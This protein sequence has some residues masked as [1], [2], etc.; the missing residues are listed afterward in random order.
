MGGFFVRK[1]N[2]SKIFRVVI[3][4][5]LIAMQIV[6][7]RLLSINLTYL[8]IGFSFIPLMFAAYLYGPAGGVIVA[9]VSDLIGAIA[10]PSGPFFPG[11]TVTAALSG[12]IFGLTFHKNL[13]TPKIVAGVIANEVICSLLLNTLWLSILYTSA[14]SVLI[15]SR[16]WQCIVMAT[17]QIAFAEVF[18]HRLKIA[19]KLKVEVLRKE[20]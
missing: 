12:F 8:K 1:F 4:S 2:N 11:F 20:K 3:I 15:T 16:I 5:I 14:F 18:F 7:S 13:S 19:K 9:T 10:M 6:L 17:I